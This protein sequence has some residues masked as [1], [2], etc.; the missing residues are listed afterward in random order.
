[1]GSGDWEVQRETGAGKYLQGIL[2]LHFLGIHEVVI[3]IFLRKIIHPQQSKG[4]NM[5]SSRQIHANRFLKSESTKAKWDLKEQL[6]KI[7][8]HK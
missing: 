5:V 6:L 2:K 3:Y 7:L 4:E 1:M 8:G